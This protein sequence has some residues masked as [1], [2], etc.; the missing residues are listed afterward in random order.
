MR[1]LHETKS[2]EDFFGCAFVPTMGALH[3]GHASLIRQARS[4]ARGSNATH[5]ESSE[6]LTP[7]G[8]HGVRGGT[9]VVATIFVNPTQFGP[10]EDF[11][12]YPRTLDADLALARD[13]GADAVFVP[14]AQ[15]I[16]PRG[17]DAAQQDA[18]AWR[19]P[20]TATEPGLEDRCRPGH[21]GGV[22]LVVAR[23][24]ALCRPRLAFFGEK[25]WQQLRV[26]SEMVERE[27]AR[28]VEARR[29][30]DLEIVPC[31]TVRERD[32][33]A[34][35]SRNRY[36][37]EQER[38]RATALWRAIGR[39]RSLLAAAQGVSPG[40][41]ADAE[42]AMR[43]ELEGDG[44]EVDYAVVRDAMS[45]RPWLGNAPR[46]SLRLLVAARLGPVRLI[47]NAEV[48]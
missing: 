3:E 4:M 20:P 25:D 27:R 30:D 14:A 33:L 17:L 46:S 34:M 36:L 28:S 23:L 22:C 29:F 43:V 13:A 26:I 47:D 2:L 18:A 12:R 35:S 32:G 16:Y 44:F 21:F 15:D 5:L 24:F 38:R 10:N 31:A 11:A 48:P 19:L 45:L 40:E 7:R 41:V 6:A 42:H 8:S 37:G 39:A 9:P 1:V